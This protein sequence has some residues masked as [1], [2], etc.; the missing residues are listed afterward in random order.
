M[1]ADTCHGLHGPRTS[2]TLWVF[3][4]CFLFAVRVADIA[5]WIYRKLA[6]KIAVVNC[7]ALDGDVRCLFGIGATVLE[8]AHY[9]SQHQCIAATDHI[10]CFVLVRSDG[11]E[12]GDNRCQ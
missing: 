1:V 10:P 11:L 9:S 4:D 5:A 6:D 12:V 3:M 8:L 7:L 2:L